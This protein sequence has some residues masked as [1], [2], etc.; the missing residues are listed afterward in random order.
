MII[1]IFSH[2][3]IILTFTLLIYWPFINYFRQNDFVQRTKSYVV[4]IKFGLAGLILT[5]P[6]ID[7]VHGFMI[8]SRI[9]LLI[10]SGLLG[11]P[12]ALLTSGIIMGVSRLFFSGITHIT[13]LININFIV[14][15]IILF[16]VMRKFKL[17][18]NIHKY[19]WGCL[20]EMTI[21]LYIG[22]CFNNQNILYSLLYAAFTIFTFY[23]ILSLI[24]QVKRS[25]DTVQ[26]TNYL[27]RI[28]YPTQLPNNFWTEEYLQSLIKKKTN[29][30]LLLFD[31]DHFRFINSQ[32]GYEVGDQVIKQLAHLLKEYSTKNDAFIGRLA[33]EEFIVILKDVAPAYAI[34]EADNFMKAIEK[35]VFKGPE[36]IHITVSVGVCS[37]P[38]NGADTLSLVKSLIEAQQHAKLNPNG[39][40]FHANNLKKQSTI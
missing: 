36:D 32:Y 12:V 27:Q 9:I 21:V 23:F 18:Q 39:S 3:C 4:G 37:Y 38:D 35:H 26:E 16:F 30:T 6:M 28:D 7:L 17:R 19:F 15:T 25:S 22:L 29:F 11:G 2:F 31:I 40:Y 5:I 10:F 1:K 8:N 20:I 14:V 24:L 34:I 13:F 33:G